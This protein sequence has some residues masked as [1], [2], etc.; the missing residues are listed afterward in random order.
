MVLYLDEWFIQR[1]GLAFGVMWAGTGLAGLVLPFVMS[2]GL[3]TFGFRAI[4]RAWAI[5]FVL[6]T[7][8][9]IYYVKPRLPVPR[10]SGPSHVSFTFLGTRIFWVLQTG[11]IIQGLGYF[12][13]SVYLPSY[14]NTS[15]YSHVIGTI[16]VSLINSTSIIGVIVMGFLVDRLHVTTVILISSLGAAASVLLIWGLASSTPVLCLFS[17]MYGIFAGGFTASWT[18]VIKEVRRTSPE[19]EAGTVLGL[20]AAGRGIGAVAS[21]PLSSKLLEVGS[22]GPG[23]GGYGTNFAVL[24]L[25]TGLTAVCGGISWLGRR[26]RII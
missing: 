20:F 12:I 23:I 13:P 14:A 10:T 2:W 21:G 3:T 9:F 19:A 8:P 17:L 25:F 4:I 22:W 11:N 7:A 1:K 16:L 15:G 24:I 6:L 18:G 26:A 5:L